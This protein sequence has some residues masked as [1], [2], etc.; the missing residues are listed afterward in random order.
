MATRPNP[1]FPPD[2]LDLVER[3]MAIEEALGGLNLTNEKREQLI[4]DIQTR[5]ANGEFGDEDDLDDALGVLVRT[6][7]PRNP[8][9]EAGA[10][11]KPEEPFFE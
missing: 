9:G 10:A 6:H 3:V 4:R 1:D 5:I 7:G 2:S 11:A 8:S